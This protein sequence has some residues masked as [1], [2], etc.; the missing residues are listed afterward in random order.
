MELELECTQLSGFETILDTTVFHEETME[1][2]VPDACPDILR[3]VDTEGMACLRTKEAQEGRAEVSGAAKAAVLYLPDGGEGLRRL[4]VSIPFS[5]AADGG[6]ITGG[7][8]VEAIPRVVAAETRSLNPRKVLVRINLAVCIRVYAPVTEN[9]CSAAA[10]PEE[11]GVEQLTEQHNTYLV[12][13]VQEKP[14][15]FSDELAI[16]AGRPEAEEILKSRFAVRCSESKIIGNKL[17][18]KGVATVRLFYRALEGGL[19][20][21]DFELP[22]SQIMEISG[23]GEEAG[24]EVAVVLTSAECNLAGGDGRMVA[25]SLG[26]LAQ[27]VVRENRGLELLTDAYSTACDMTTETRPCTLRRLL[28]QGQRSQSARELVETGVLAR[29]VLDTYTGVGAITQS[30]DGSRVT[31]TAQVGTTVLY[32]GED[33]GIYA[34]TRQI[35]VTCPLDL[36]EGGSCFCLCREPGECSAAPTSGG[37]EVRVEVEFQYLALSARQVSVIAS[38]HMEERDGGGEGERPSIVLRMAQEG[39]RLWD[40]AKAYGTTRIDIRSANS[41]GEEESLSDRLLLIPRKR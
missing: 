11:A 5:C 4:E 28:D 14:F 7:C 2:I 27:A 40:I 25:V 10:G 31:V 41:L 33:E 26:L 17:I 12:V 15:T 20:S 1:M 24:C 19:Y 16:S 6:E 38:A 9:L 13:C 23:A 29:E 8:T 35:P 18:I 30:R 21:T 22:F 36:P 39:E 32:Q 3:I 37:L 34:V